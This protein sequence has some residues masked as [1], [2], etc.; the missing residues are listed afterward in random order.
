MTHN[1]LA[2]L[3]LMSLDYRFV[4]FCVH[5]FPVCVFPHLYK[6]KQRNLFKQVLAK[7]HSF[8]HHIFQQ[9]QE[10]YSEQQLGILVW[11]CSAVNPSS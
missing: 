5:V 9:D 4:S 3:D 11:L 1:S 6:C 7:Q 10:P 2:F 8:I